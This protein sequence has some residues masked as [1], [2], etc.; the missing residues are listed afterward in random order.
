MTT[1]LPVMDVT[2]RVLGAP[3]DGQRSPKAVHSRTVK[4]AVR[5]RYVISAHD[6]GYHDSTKGF[7]CCANA[8]GGDAM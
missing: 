2:L 8:V 1:A 3:G 7:R 5:G 4:H 6:L